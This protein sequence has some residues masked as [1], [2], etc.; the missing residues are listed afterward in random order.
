MVASL[1]EYTN[2]LVKAKESPVAHTPAWEEAIDSL[3]LLMAPGFPFI[4][5]EMWTIRGR[6]YSVH[7]QSW[8]TWDETLAAEE[9]L[10]IVVQ[11]NGKL[12]GRFEVATDIS[13]EEAKDQALKLESVE[14]HL[15][16]KQIKKVIYVPGR[17][18]NI[19]VK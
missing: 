4:S 10:T 17:L 7:L 12:R 1:M 8:P 19:V 5:E 14:K 15:E 18:V 6:P 3:V 9:I 16:G 11:V 2:F 13:Q